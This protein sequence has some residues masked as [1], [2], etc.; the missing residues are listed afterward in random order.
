MVG[1]KKKT[2]TKK[3]VTYAKISPRMVNPRDMAGE[4]RRK[5]R[6][7]RRKKKKKKKKEGMPELGLAGLVSIYSDWVNLPP[8]CG[9]T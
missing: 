5:R 8:Q 2:K 7:R 9:G 1:L 3:L 6:R 4:H